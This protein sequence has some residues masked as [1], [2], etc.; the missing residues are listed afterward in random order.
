[1]STHS[2]VRKDECCDSEE[3]EA[4]ECRT[5]AV[6]AKVKPAGII[7][8]YYFIIVESS[9]LNAVDR[10]CVRKVT[11]LRQQMQPVKH[12]LSNMAAHFVRR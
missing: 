1:M 5:S 4:R 8:A 10:L 3:E 7:R 6:Q 11:L 12:F 9:V 2:L